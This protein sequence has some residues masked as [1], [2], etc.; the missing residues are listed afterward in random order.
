M[1]TTEQIILDFKKTHKN[2]YDYSLVKYLNAKIKVKIICKEH[3]VFEQLPGH[4]KKGNGCPKCS[5]KNNILTQDKVIKDFEKIHNKLYDYSLLIY[6]N[7]KEKVKIICKEHGVF[8]QKPSKHKSGNGCPKCA[9]DK[10]YKDKMTFLYYIKVYNQYKIGICLKG[11]YKNIY[12]AINA[13]YNKEIKK[14][15]KIEIIKSELFINGSEAYN[16]EQKIRINNAKYLISK[17]DMILNSGFT[18]TF[19]EDVSNNID[20]KVFELS[21]SIINKEK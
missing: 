5:I 18:E 4:H 2:K 19:N 7:S 20:D 16:L 3:G 14:G 17:C 12:S 9:K 8:E 11:K 10:H 15:I 6:K 13:R 21:E 1:K